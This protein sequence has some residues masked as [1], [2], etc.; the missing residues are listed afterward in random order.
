VQNA[1]NN[2]IGRYLYD[3]DGRRVKKVVPATGE[4]T[5]FVYDASGRMMVEYSTIVEPPATAKV[6]YLT[7]D[8]LWERRES[9]PMQM[10]M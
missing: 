2:V 6:S 10:G 7:T 9:T 3:G 8:H 1:A 5:I 4:V